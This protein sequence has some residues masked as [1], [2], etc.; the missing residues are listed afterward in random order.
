MTITPQSNG[1]QPLVCFA[2]G[3]ES[4]PYGT[5]IRYLAT[6]AEAFGAKVI[7]PDYSNI[8]LPDDRVK[9]LLALALPAHSR[10]ILVGS[11]MGG[12]VSAVAS[13]HLKPDGLFL[14]APAVFMP[15]YEEPSPEP[16][17]VENSVVFG[18][19]DEV[20]PVH[21]G[22]RYAE[23]YRT[24]LHL[25]NADHRLN[26]ALAEIGVLFE[27]FLKRVLASSGGR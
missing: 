5:K 12:Y 11:S 18:W 16:V 8:P 2:H 24:T 17:A 19:R 22:I 14:L 3:K 20:I 9:H 27:A 10:L 6:I 21:H 26:S 15:G 23:Q 25:L 1:N 4:G 7:S 13:R